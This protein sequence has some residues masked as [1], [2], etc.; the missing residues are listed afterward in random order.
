M[1]AKDASA[2]RARERW[3]RRLTRRLRRLP[4]HDAGLVVLG[5]S[6]SIALVSGASAAAAACL[7]ALVLLLAER[8]VWRHTHA[9]DLRERY[10][11]L[12]R[13]A[14]A[15]DER[16]RALSDSEAVHRSLTETFGDLAVEL[17]D[18][19]MTFANA[20][21]RAHFPEASLPAIVPDAEMAEGE[22]EVDTA[23]GSRVLRWRLLPA[24]DARGRSVRRWIARDVTDTT[25][26]REAAEAARIEAERRAE[27]KGRFLAV[28]AHE[29]R[30]PLSGIRGMA[31]LLG[32]GTLDAHAR[33]QVTAITRS[34]AALGAVI[35][36]LLDDARM[37]ADRLEVECEPFDPGAVLEGV[38]ELA[39]RAAHE[40]GLDLA[41]HTVRH[42][43]E[44]VPCF[45]E[46]DA[47][48]VGQIVANLVGNALKFTENGGV[49]VLS[50]VR[51]GALS[52]EVRD[53]GPGLSENEC[54]RIFDVFASGGDAQ[55]AAR[56]ARRLGGVGLGLH[57]SRRLADA[58]GGT[59][60]VESR[61]GEG[62][63]F[64]F[65]LPCEARERPDSTALEG[66]RV[67]LVTERRTLAAP[68]RRFVEERGGRLVLMGAETWARR[69]A[70]GDGPLLLDEDIELDGRP[71]DAVLLVRTGSRPDP[72]ARW[73][74]LPWR[75]T[76]LERALGG[77]TDVDREE[78]SVLR[79]AIDTGGPG[80]SVLVAED[81]PV[82]QLLSTAVLERAGHRVT[83]AATGH[84]AARLYREAAESETPFEAVLLDVNLTASGETGMDGMAALEAM[85][86]IEK[87]RDLA[88]APVHVVTGDAQALTAETALKAGATSVH[89]K[90]VPVDVL[91]GLMQA[92][93]EERAA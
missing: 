26:A 44:A 21:F 61:P 39:A 48:R 85:R 69:G 88:P 73:L 68:L 51:N 10:R 43:P 86:L 34:T 20:A 23:R 31:E 59:L 66:Q 62:S 75:A 82:T 87:A 22:S 79:A 2:I 13:R 45:V 9:C 36:D 25:R 28:A 14:E 83:L 47:G 24:L 16:L 55:A 41:V 50:R 37:E 92:Q 42:G 80:R 91:A 64:T 53:T 49:S 12:G 15:L 6:T 71:D 76:S 4:L 29:L 70:W 19:R 78:P 27:A 30:N 58:M 52:V 7:L 46:G 63:T 8:W 17:R 38:C 56:M 72:A 11:A 57:I 84:D 1:T 74:R 32:T 89:V 18:G 33:A 65:R 90:P 81:D 3:T 54:A 67:C 5:L 77:R 60:D 40:K 35:D 93:P